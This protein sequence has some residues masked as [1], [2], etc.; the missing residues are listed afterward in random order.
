MLFLLIKKTTNYEQNCYFIMGYKLQINL[1]DEFIN[2]FVEGELSNSELQSFSELQNRDVSIRSTAQSGVRVRKYLKN[3]RTVKCRP[4]FDQRMA[5][6]FAVE[7]EREV[8]ERNKN[9]SSQPAVSS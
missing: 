5:A 2:D 7:L 1:L 3:L 8:I 4:G 9:R 6:K